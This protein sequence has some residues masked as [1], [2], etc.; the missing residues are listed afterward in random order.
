[1]SINYD[2]RLDMIV[3]DH[4]APFEP[5]LSGN[6]AFYGPDGSFDGFK[7]ENGSFRWYRDVDARNF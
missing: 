5:I 4:L 6:F 7:F 2:E 1:M 3:F